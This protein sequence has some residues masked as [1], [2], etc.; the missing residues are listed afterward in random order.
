ME[1]IKGM[2]DF[3]PHTEGEIKEMMEFLGISSIDEL[4]SDIPS[5]FRV[6]KLGLDKGKDEREIFLSALQVARKNKF[7]M[8]SLAGGG[9]YFHYVPSVCDFVSSLP[10][11]FTSYTPYQ[12]E[13]SQGVMKMLYDFQS[14]MVELFDMDVANAGMYGGASSLAEACLMAER[15]MKRTGIGKKKVLISAGVNPRW[16]EVVKTYLEPLDIEFELIPLKNGRTQIPDNSDIFVIQYPNFFGVVE[17]LE[18]ARRRTKGVLIVAVPDP[19]DLSVLPPPGEFSADIVVSEGQPLGNYPYL[20]GATLGIFLAKKDDIRQIPGRIIGKT[21]DMDGK[22]AYA[23]ILQT[24]E[25]HIRREKATSNICTSTVL[26][27]LRAVA[28]LKYYGSEGLREIAQ[29]SEK[30]SLFLRKEKI[31]PVFETEFFKEFPVYADVDEENLI[32]LGVIP[33]LKVKRVIPKFLDSLEYEKLTGVGS[34]AY[35]FCTT[36]LLSE[37]ILKKS[38]EFIKQK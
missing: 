32:S 26:L 38:L 13:L 24:R 4:F 30:L 3:I 16:I 11:F 37:D 10:G 7:S 36:E 35:L 6:E 21:T 8:F 12:A 25:Q 15:K 20:G 17:D 5:E 28:F 22:T 31:K 2:A 14:L 9:V 18:E 27:A 33:P 23:M 34:D 29:R 1:K 19:I